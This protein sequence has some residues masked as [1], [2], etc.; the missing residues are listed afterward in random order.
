MIFCRNLR[1]ITFR[2]TNVI[3]ERI[4]F[5]S[6]SIIWTYPVWIR[7]WPCDRKPSSKQPWGNEGKHRDWH[8]NHQQWHATNDLRWIEL[9]EWSAPCVTRVANFAFVRLKTNCD[10]PCA[11][12]P[13]QHV[14][15]T[16]NYRIINWLTCSAVFESPCTYV[17]DSA[18]V[19]WQ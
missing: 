16:M 3:P 1:E 19:T 7:Q 4:I 14:N 5:V 18:G 2:L 17:Q 12:R 6:P 10:T 11:N 8:V 9:D 15:T 13:R